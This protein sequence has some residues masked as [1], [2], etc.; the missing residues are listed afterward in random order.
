[1]DN[2]ED[3]DDDD[4]VVD[5]V[6]GDNEDTNE[7]DV[8]VDDDVGED[9]DTGCVVVVVVVVKASVI[10]SSLEKPMS[11]TLKNTIDGSSARLIV[12][13]DTLC[14]LLRFDGDESDDG[15]D[16]TDFKFCANA[17]S[18]ARTPDDSSLLPCSLINAD[19][20]RM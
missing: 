15:D 4:D 1:M 13:N 18:S 11:A 12:P 7:D 16:D 5:D 6:V 3:T 14:L 2:D 20:S 8:V 9:E 19:D 17:S 10:R